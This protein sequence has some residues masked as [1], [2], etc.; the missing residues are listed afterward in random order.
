MTDR[1]RR[2]PRPAMCANL[3][4]WTAAA[5]LSV[6]R[7]AAS[8]NAAV[9]SSR[10]RARRLPV[11][12]SNLGL[13]PARRG[14]SAEA[15]VHTGGGQSGFRH[16][17]VRRR[18]SGSRCGSSFDASSSISRITAASGQFSDRASAHSASSAP[19]PWPS[20]RAGANLKTGPPVPPD[21][22]LFYR[23]AQF[24]HRR[25]ELLNWSLWPND[26]S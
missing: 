18:P 8:R 5:L 16:H 15:V 6:I 17:A 7:S 1:A 2:R 11:C 3:P 26:L 4:N 21:I 25:P 13:A 24:F 14:R 10:S 23:S 19:R 9:S 20:G 22:R 12:V